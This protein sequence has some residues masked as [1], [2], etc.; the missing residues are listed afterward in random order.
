MP[1]LLHID[2][3]P[4]GETSITRRLSGE[5]VQNWIRANPEGEVIRRDLAATHLPG[6]DAQ[7]VRALRSPE[8]SLTPDQREVLALSNTLVAEL[9]RA[10]E[11]VLGVPMHNFTIPAVFRLWV[12]QVVRAG[13]TF[14]YVNG[15]PAG[16]MKNKKA[17]V[18]IASGGV[19]DPGS[20]TAPLDFVQPYLRTIF[21]FIGV[22][23]TT[24]HNAGGAAAV[25]LGKVDRQVFLAPHI[26]AIRAGFQPAS[27]LL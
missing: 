5:F 20:P 17:H 9:E 12:D 11:W 26:D 23:N 16:L 8:N 13:K 22:T 4:I 27:G 15:S 2:S 7:W 3:S 21:G 10:D 24:F 14:A 25:S 6:I 1:T 19:Y 18:F